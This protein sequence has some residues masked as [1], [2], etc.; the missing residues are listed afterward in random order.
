MNRFTHGQRN[1]IQNDQ[2]IARTDRHALDDK[3]GIALI[4][5]ASHGRRLIRLAK[6]PQKLLAGSTAASR[7][8]P[9]RR[10]RS[11]LLPVKPSRLGNMP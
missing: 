6:R 4:H 7:C 5:R 8:L 2:R 1:A 9:G 11:I 10:K 3:P